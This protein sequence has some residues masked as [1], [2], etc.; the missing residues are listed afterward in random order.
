MPF[1]PGNQWWK[2]RETHGRPG[3]FKTADD[4]REAIESYFQWNEDNPLYE[5]NVSFYQGVPTHEKLEKVRALTIEGLCLHIGIN[6]QTWAN[7][8]ND[9][10]KPDDFIGVIDW[11]ENVMRYQKFTNAA[12]GLLNANIISRD[13]G[14]ADKQDMT[15]SDGS[16]SQKPTTIQLVAPDDSRSDPDTA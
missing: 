4:L 11:A 9:S 13:L 2:M 15:S 8:R 14:L 5:D 10:E 12:A 7:W 3:I 16:M 1:Q 6:R